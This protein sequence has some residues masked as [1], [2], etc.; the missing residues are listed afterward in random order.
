MK[1]VPLNP[2]PSQTLNLTLNNQPLKLIIYTLSTGLFM[3]V[4]LNNVTIVSGVICL[5]NNKIVREAYSGLIGD[6]MFTDTQGS[7]DPEYS[8]LGSRYLLV[9]LEASDL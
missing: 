9:Y 4:K 7:S 6:F 3:D 8:G 5:N 2:V 1:T